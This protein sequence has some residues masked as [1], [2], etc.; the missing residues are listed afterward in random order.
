[1]LEYSHEILWDFN[2]ISFQIISLIAGDKKVHEKVTG[3]D[4]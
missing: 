4:I 1:M 2:S 3:L